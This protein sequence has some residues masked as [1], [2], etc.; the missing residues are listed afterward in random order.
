[1]RTTSTSPNTFSYWPRN[2][3]I[4][5][6][7]STRSWTKIHAPTQFERK[8]QQKIYQQK[9]QESHTPFRMSSSYQFILSTATTSAAITS[10]K[11]RTNKLNKQCSQQSGPQ[12]WPESNRWWH[13]V[14]ATE[15]DKPK[16]RQQ[17]SEH[18][19][20][21]AHL[22]LGLDIAPRQSERSSPLLDQQQ[23]NQKHQRVGEPRKHSIQT[24][25]IQIKWK[26]ISHHHNNISNN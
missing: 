11:D 4:T 7:S 15:K 19:R 5:R 23:T 18:R 6:S 10:I 9:V 26:W 12:L 21:V 17:P 8:T 1:M 25:G 13:Q 22:V 2:R 3:H 14:Q 20:L 16:S 24:C